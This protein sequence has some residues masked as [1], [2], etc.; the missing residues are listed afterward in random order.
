M[1]HWQP[2]R[3]SSHRWGLRKAQPVIGRVGQ[4][5]LQALQPH[6]RLHRRLA[7]GEQ[8]VLHHTGRKLK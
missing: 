1:P 8:G 2:A 3:L 7:V 5:R 6:T 4:A